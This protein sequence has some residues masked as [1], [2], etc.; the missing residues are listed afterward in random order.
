M[1]HA[2]DMTS[3]KAVDEYSDMAIDSLE[4]IA[5]T[6]KGLAFRDIESL[7]TAAQVA[8]LLAIAEAIRALTKV[9]EDRN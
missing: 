6:R 1:T 8:A 5:Q 9:I 3:N 2:K 4:A 7:S